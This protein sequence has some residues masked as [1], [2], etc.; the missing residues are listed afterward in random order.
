MRSITGVPAHSAFEGTSRWGLRD[1][2]ASVRRPRSGLSWYATA[3]E[4]AACATRSAQGLIRP[5]PVEH[6]PGCLGAR[7]S[8]VVALSDAGDYARPR[9]AVRPSA[10]RRPRSAPSVIHVPGKSSIRSTSGRRRS[11]TSSPVRFARRA[12][13]PGVLCGETIALRLRSGPF[14]HLRF[15]DAR[16]RTASRPLAN[17]G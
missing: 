10:R 4:L 12:P 15:L 2:N 5:S 7:C 3:T 11:P 6:R 8:P 14:R 1:A 9:P 16:R 17:P 13:Y